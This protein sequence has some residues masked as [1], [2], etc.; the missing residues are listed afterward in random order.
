MDLGGYYYVY[1]INETTDVIFK[2]CVEFLGSKNLEVLQPYHSLRPSVELL[3][4]EKE[5]IVL[6]SMNS[7]A[8]FTCRVL[9]KMSK[10]ENRKSLNDI[11]K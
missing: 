8:Q 7:R 10:M 2:G 11:V 1:L 6:N 9:G 5:V 4:G 3:P